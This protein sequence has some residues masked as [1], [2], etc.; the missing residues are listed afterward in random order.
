[1]R[2]LPVLL[3]VA[4]CGGVLLSLTLPIG[5]GSRSRGS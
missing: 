1:M 4:L 2:L 5:S 3:A